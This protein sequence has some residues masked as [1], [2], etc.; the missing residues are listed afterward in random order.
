MSKKIYYTYNAET[1]NFERLYPSLKSRLISWSKILLISSFIGCLIFLLV[2][3]IFETPT[4]DNLKKENKRLKTQY[5]LLNK[6]LDN[7]IETLERLRERDDNLYRVMLQLEPMS[8]SQRMAGIESSNLSYD[9]KRLSDE[10]LIN[11]LSRKMD[12]IEHQ[13]YSQI[14]SIEQVHNSITHQKEK[15]A[16][17]PSVIPIN[18]N[19]YTMSSGYGYRIDPIYGTSKFHEGLDFSASV[20]T[21][22]FAT[23][24]GVVREAGRQAGYGNC[25]EIDHGFNYVTRYAHL[26]DICIREGEAV[27]R[28]Q[29]IGKVG[30]TGKSTGPHLHYEVRFKDEAQNPVN[31][32]FMD[33]TPK[34]YALMIQAAEDAGQVMD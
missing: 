23:A 5:G 7:T 26:S 9:G 27:R 34:E 20:G 32:Y 17:I 24:D 22:V 18:I 1:D 8:T 16:H 25:I 31:Y 2:F 13:I 3:V 11:E 30:S 4:E 33:L 10:R 28:G 29:L 6:R 12:L 14:L 15:L 19:D 21:D